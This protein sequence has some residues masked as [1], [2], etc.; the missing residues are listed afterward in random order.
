[1]TNGLAERGRE[2]HDGASERAAYFSVSHG[3]AVSWLKIGVKT[4]VEIF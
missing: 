1:M 3:N 2:Q 4:D